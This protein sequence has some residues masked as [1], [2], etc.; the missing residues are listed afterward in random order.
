M[1]FIMVTGRTVRQGEYIDNKLSQKYSTETSTCFMNPVDMMNMYLEEGDNIRI[2]TETGAVVFRALS[3]DGLKQGTVF[4]PYGPYCNMLVS[5]C[6]HGTGMP[7]YKSSRIKIEPTDQ[8]ILSL[9]ELLAGAG[10]KE[11]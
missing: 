3:D 9:T 6:T 8:D 5:T 10:G 4:I 1:K 7:D 11:I 2:A